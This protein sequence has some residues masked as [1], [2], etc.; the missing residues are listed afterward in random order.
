MRTG[1]KRNVPKKQRGRCSGHCCACFYLP[2]SPDALEA[3]YMRWVKLHGKPGPDQ[4]P[5]SMSNGLDAFNGASA[6]LLID[7]HLIYPML[8]YLGEGDRLMPKQIRE[9]TTER[10]EERHYYSCVHWDQRT[11]NC[12]IY[13]HRP[14]MCREYPYRDNGC[15]YA[16]CTWTKR[17]VK[18]MTVR[19]RK[20]LEAGELVQIGAKKK[21]R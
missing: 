15:N 9:V 19:E 6:S 20:E 11:G 18:P 16:G 1:K 5:V 2:Y 3:A 14:Q 7:I 12:Q 17:K 21:V 13:E 8:I 10:G 4:V